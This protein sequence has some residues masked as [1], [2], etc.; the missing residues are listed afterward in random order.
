MKLSTQDLT[1]AGLFTALHI[2]AAVILRLGGEAAVPFSLVPFFVILA[3]SLLG[4]KGAWSLALYAVLGLIGLPVF[5]QPPFGG[6][7][8]F[9]RPSAGFIL[10]YIVAAWVIGWGTS[11]LPKLTVVNLFLVS[12]LGLAVLYACG[13]PY[14]YFIFRCVM[15]KTLTLQQVL[16]FGFYPFIGFDLLKALAAS[17][18]TVAIRRRLA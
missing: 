2:A 9:L 6:I 5:A 18:L 17:M 15:G 11:R 12:V 10:G 8:Y 16:I 7:S 14:L 13:L 3:G 1:K 4:P